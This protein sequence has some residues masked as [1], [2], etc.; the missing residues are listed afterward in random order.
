MSVDMDALPAAALP[1]VPTEGQ[2]AGV[3][4][5]LAIIHRDGGHYA[6]E[7]GL[8]KALAEAGALV[9]ARYAGEVG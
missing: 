3:L 2:D 6:V 1:S 8:S 7:H 5:L 4:D 9:S